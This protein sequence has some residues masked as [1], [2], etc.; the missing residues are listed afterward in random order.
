MATNYVQPFNGDEL[1]L[2]LSNAMYYMQLKWSK[3]Y[4]FQFFY[5]N[6]PR[7]YWNDINEYDNGIMKPY[8]TNMTG[9]DE[10]V[11]NGRLRGLFFSAN[12]ING[13]M[14]YSSPYG[15]T[16]YCFPA[17]ELLNE[18]DHL[19]FADFFCTNP[20]KRNHT[21]V[22]VVCKPYSGA[23]RWCQRKYLP[24]LDIFNN[25]FLEMDSGEYYVNDK[26]WVH[27]MYTE[28]V[29]LRDMGYYETNVPTTG[30]GHSHPV[31]LPVVPDCRHCNIFY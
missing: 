22:I 23:D 3:M 6:K 29:D 28:N 10:S 14:P 1:D 21:V 2:L 4:P 8:Y 16:R 27:L 18:R 30:L 15:D 20:R 26:V 24:R 19:Y 12:L 7:D 9:H 5:R 11:I 17:E 13:D 25:P 31:G